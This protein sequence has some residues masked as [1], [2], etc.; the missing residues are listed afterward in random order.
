MGVLML[1]MTICGLAAAIVLLIY[2]FW[3]KR[4]W[5]KNFV[6][7]GVVI[8]LIGYFILLF[9]GSFYSEEKTLAFNQPK[10]FCGFYF[11]C[12]LHAA[13]TGVC[14]SK[15]FGAMTAQNEFYIVKVKVFNDAKRETL[16]LIKPDFTVI[17]A[18]GREF[19][20][21]EDLTVTVETPK[22][23]EKIPAGGSVEDEIAFDLPSD[24]QNPR[25]DIREGYGIDHAIEAVLIGDEDSI[26]HKRSYFKIEPLIQTASNR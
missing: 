11:D 24:A 3:T 6:A 1:L 4:D 21:S 9:A 13:V 14:R 7:G 23:E 2:A 25:L 5:L 20:S 15:T 12:H 16:A 22:F 10:E 26:G 17:D 8:W 19:K 18:Q